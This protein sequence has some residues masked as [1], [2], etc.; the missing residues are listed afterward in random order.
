MVILSERLRGSEYQS[1]EGRQIRLPSDP[2]DRPSA[3]ALEK[4]KVLLAAIG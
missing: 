1:F 4:R 3:K 2:R